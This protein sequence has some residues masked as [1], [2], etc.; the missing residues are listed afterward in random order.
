MYN[1][2]VLSDFSTVISKTVDGQT[3]HVIT[4][5]YPI[6]RGKKFESEIEARTWAEDYINS[7][8]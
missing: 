4:T 5:N 6:N 3:A 8:M 2:E 7:L 1:I